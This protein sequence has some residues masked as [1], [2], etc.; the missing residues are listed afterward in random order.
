MPPPKQSVPR[1]QRA[2]G[3]KDF[4]KRRTVD[5]GLAGGRV[6]PDLSVGAVEGSK[7]F[8]ASQNMPP[9]VAID[10][11]GREMTFGAEARAWRS[12]VLGSPIKAQRPG[13]GTLDRHLPQRTG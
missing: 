10:D 7:T 8:G 2:P 6:C 3:E 9:A 11:D 4:T 13:A 5:E 1:K 12:H